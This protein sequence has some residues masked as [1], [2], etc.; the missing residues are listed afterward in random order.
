MDCMMPIMDGFEATQTIRMTLD[1]QECLIVALSAMTHKADL[2]KGA[3]CGMDE[4]LTK[5]PQLD[6]LRDV[7]EKI[8]GLIKRN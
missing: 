5:P 1:K 7:I 3:Q 4:F 8:F 2:E 6:Q